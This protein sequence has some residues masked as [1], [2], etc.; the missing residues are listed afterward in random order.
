VGGSAEK[1]NGS[2]WF[3]SGRCGG[4]NC[5][6]IHRRRNELMV[7]DSK[8]RGLIVLMFGKKAWSTFIA[9]YQCD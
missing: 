7:R 2:E 9:S 3:R 6:E 4:G 8:N 1:I 5:V